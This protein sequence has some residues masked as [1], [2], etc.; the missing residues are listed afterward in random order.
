MAG[1]RG[2]RQRPEV[3]V[4]DLKL[5][6]RFDP[7]DARDIGHPCRIISNLGFRSDWS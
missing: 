3:N 1:K 5:Q 2:F 7:S 6:M 4:K